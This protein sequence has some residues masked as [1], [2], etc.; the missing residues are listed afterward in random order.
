[1]HFNFLSKLLLFC[2]HFNLIFIS[3]NIPYFANFLNLFHQFFSQ[4]PL[5][6]VSNFFTIN[7]HHANMRISPT[8]FNF[9][10]KIEILHIL[11]FFICI[12]IIFSLKAHFSLDIYFSTV[13]LISCFTKNR[14]HKP[15]N[16]KY[17][18]KYHHLP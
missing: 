3:K 1:M 13:Q 10:I 2:L 17:F 11:Y 5:S 15:K 14:V 9:S 8:Q 6:F 16:I 4:I 7:Q 18:Q 12:Q